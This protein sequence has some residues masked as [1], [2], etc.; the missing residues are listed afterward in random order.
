[1][2]KEAQFEMW[3]SNEDHSRPT[4]GNKGVSYIS[5]D[6]NFDPNYNSA[7]WRG[8]DFNKILQE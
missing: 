3:T 8:C 4:W 7:F 1:M 2:L 6:F 5:K